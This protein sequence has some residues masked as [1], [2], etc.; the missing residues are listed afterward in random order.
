MQVKTADLNSL[1]N[2][3]FVVIFARYQDKWLYCRAK[4]RDAFETAGGHI[5]QGETP[6][7]AAKR[8]LYEETG[9]IKYDIT[10][11]FDYSVHKPEGYSCGQVFLARIQKLGD[12]P[13][14]E[15]AEVRLFDSIPDKMRFPQ[16][17]P[18]LYEKFQNGEQYYA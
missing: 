13:E 17:L 9:A 5:E 12:I 11:A 16:I 7:D 4:E 2:Y 8:E 1:K 18:V 15:M 10:P 14:Y 3:S 6:L